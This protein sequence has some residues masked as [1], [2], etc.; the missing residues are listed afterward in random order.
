MEVVANNKPNLEQILTGQ[1]EV[2]AP[3]AGAKGGKAAPSKAAAVEQIQLEEGDTEL[4]D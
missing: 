2:S 4:F 3:V 1:S